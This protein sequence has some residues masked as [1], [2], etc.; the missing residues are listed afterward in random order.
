MLAA[1]HALEA[2]KALRTPVQRK[3]D[4]Q[5]LFADKMH[6]GVPIADGIEAVQ[7][8]VEED[9]RGR[10]KVDMKGQVTP[11]LL[12]A[13]GASQG[14]VLDAH[15]GYDAIRAWVAW[16]A[17]EALAARPDVAFI[18]PAARAM[19]HVGSVTSQGVVTHRADVA[20]SQFKATGKGV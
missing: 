6:R 17:L 1:I 20:A 19:T 4:S 18:Q 8:R 12:G 3:I 16:G 10:V 7:V 14:E 2:D 5:L 9:P 13:I 11:G 15:E